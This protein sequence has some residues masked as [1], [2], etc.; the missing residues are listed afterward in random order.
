MRSSA[1][2]IAAAVVLLLEG[3]ALGVVSVIELIALGS[4]E[5]ASNTGGIALIALTLIA[6]LALC[7]FSWGTLRRASWAR[8]GGVVFQALGIALGLA[9]LTLEPKVW[10]FTIAVGVVSLA[11][12]ANDHRHV[13]R[14]G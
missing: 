14:L 2:A 7:V 8:S 6:A 12:R 11:E 13:F 1:P 4:G 3:I 9:S 10:L 5:T